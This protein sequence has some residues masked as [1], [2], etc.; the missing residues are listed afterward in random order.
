M[1]LQTLDI[2]LLKPAPYNPRKPLSPGMPAFDK[3]ER[4][5]AEFDLVQPVV[6]NRA[7]GHVV[8]G[9]QRLEVLKHRGVT[10]VDCI[11][12]ELSLEREKALN[13]ALNNERLASTWDDAKLADLLTE[14]QD[15]PDFDATL[16]GFDDADL[17]DLL[18]EPQLP[19]APDEPEDAV[20]RVTLEVP[21]ERWEVVRPAIDEFLAA[22]RDV[23]I[24]VRLP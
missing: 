4:S 18:F 7:T 21:P 15:I 17:R 9:H 19:E 1:N 11:V 20:V 10:L 5:L 16:T 6:W 12:V 3:L 24:H 8:A 14:L 2:S 23:R 13:V 22:H